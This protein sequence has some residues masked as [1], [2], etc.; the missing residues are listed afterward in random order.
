MTN[1]QIRPQLIFWDRNVGFFKRAKLKMPEDYAGYDLEKN[2][3][4]G[5]G[6]MP[7]DSLDLVSSIYL[8]PV[9]IFEEQINETT[10]RDTFE[11]LRQHKHGNVQNIVGMAD[12]IA[13]EQKARYFAVNIIKAP[14]DRT[15]KFTL[16]D[17]SLFNENL[18]LKNTETYSIVDKKLKV[19]T[20]KE[21]FE[22]VLHPT[23]Q[24]Y[25]PR[26]YK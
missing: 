12:K 26:H 2:I 17:N 25:L 3:E 9:N 7:Q 19:K 11:R 24:L 10:R 15:W 1:D 13:N 4:L 23:V 20:P 22:F 6:E 21:P 5:D 16:E 8:G 14:K 18:V